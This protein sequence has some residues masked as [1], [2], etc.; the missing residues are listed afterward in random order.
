[1]FNKRVRRKVLL[2][3]GFAWSEKTY[4]LETNVWRPHGRFFSILPDCDKSGCRGLR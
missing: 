1:M 2:S 4:A 3:A